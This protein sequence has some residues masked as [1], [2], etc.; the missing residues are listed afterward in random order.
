[1]KYYFTF[2]EIR[3]GSIY[4]E[5]ETKPTEDDVMD[6]IDKE[7]AYYGVIDYYDIKLTHTLGKQSKRNPH[8]ER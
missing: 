8:M 7:K 1:M 4:I 6:A 3:F 5:S 2:K